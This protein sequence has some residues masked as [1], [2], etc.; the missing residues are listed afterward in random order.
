MLEFKEASE[1]MLFC[2]VERCYF[3]AVGCSAEHG[4][5]ADDQQFAQVVP[6]LV[7]PGIGG[8]VEGGEKDVHAGNGL[9]KSVS[10]PRIHLPENRQTPQIKS[11]R[12]RDSPGTIM[13]M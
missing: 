10:R 4:N 12:K 9:Q 5:K 1:N 11:D 8:V 6:H 3:G 2:P 13:W 7:C